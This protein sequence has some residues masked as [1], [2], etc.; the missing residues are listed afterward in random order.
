MDIKIRCVLVDDELPRL[1]YLK[2]L[3]L[4]IPFVEVVKTYNRAEKLLAEKGL[5]TFDV[6]LLDI[7]MPV[8]GGMELAR[9]LACPVIFTT[10][11]KDY[12]AEAFEIHA[13]DYLI[14]PINRTRLRE[15]FERARILLSARKTAPVVAL[16][17]D[18]GKSIID[19]E[20]IAVV[21]TSASDPR[22]KHVLFENGN[23]IILKNYSFETIGEY[24]KAAKMIRINKGQFIAA[25]LVRV[26]TQGQVT[27]QLGERALSLP[28]G[29]T[30]R[31]AFLLAIGG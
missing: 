3:C 27:V 15:A 5:Y 17:T 25:R 19:F 11:Y 9:A 10:A 23:E 8:I 29:S 22:D 4:E 21:T 30:Y 13:I 18:R 20:K 24:M 7:E 31:A 16:N 28:L 2:A 12:A 14:K 26:Y 1:E 6:A